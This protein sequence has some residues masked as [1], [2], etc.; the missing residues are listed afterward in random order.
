MQLS[1]AEKH[2]KLVC[3]RANKTWNYINRSNVH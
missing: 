1:F 3:K 2:K